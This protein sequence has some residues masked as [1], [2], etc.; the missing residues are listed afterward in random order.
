MWPEAEPVTKQV[1]PYD[2]D[3]P[4]LSAYEIYLVKKGLKEQY[5]DRYDKLVNAFLRASK[6]PEY[7][8]TAEELGRTPALV[9]KRAEEFED[10]FE[11]RYNL[12]QETKHLW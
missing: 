12:F 3:I 4:I 8:K 6:D 7:L 1:K 11:E 10:E 9:W 5:P 2:V